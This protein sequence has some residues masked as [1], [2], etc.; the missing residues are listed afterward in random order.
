MGVGEERR[1]PP[2]ADPPTAPLLRQR[3]SLRPSLILFIPQPALGLRQS[4]RHRAHSF[5]HPCLLL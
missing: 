3:A 5:V 4:G 2:P 1:D